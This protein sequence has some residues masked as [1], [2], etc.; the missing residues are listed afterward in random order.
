MQ[1]DLFLAVFEVLRVEGAE[2]KRVAVVIV[3]SFETGC[4]KASCTVECLG[5]GFKLG[6]NFCS[7][8]LSL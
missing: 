5:L 3:V 2:S 1:A 6:S 4:H 7:F 8:G